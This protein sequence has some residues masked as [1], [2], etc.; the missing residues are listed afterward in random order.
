MSASAHTHAFDDDNRAAERRTWA[1]VAITAVMMA[2]EIVGGWLL[3]S[4]AVFADGWHMSTHAAALGIAGLAYA[5]TRRRASDGRYAFGPWKVEALASY[6]SAVLL[7]VVAL[8]MAYQSVERLR[9]PL[10]ISYNEALTLAAVGLAVNIA[11]AFVL[12]SG[13]SHHHGH[14]EPHGHRDHRDHHGHRDLNLRAAY[15][16]VIADAATSVGAIVALVLARFL[17]F[18]L[19]DPVMGIVSSVLICSWG[20]G[21]LRD[22]SAVLVDREPDTRLAKRVRAALEAE[23]ETSVLDL[24]LWRVGRSGYACA[25][26]VQDSGGRDVDHYREVL[27]RH[28]EIVHS[29]IELVAA[30]AGSQEGR[31]D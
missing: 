10:P 17:S 31:S 4:M 28:R 22:A 27:G 19:L 9:H 3:N 16:H 24:H 30:P 14:H 2:A 13:P 12:R 15:V 5:Y 1:V 18:S 6:T 29:T 20:Y 11:C 21:L 25:M 8:L 26:M 7:V 23:A